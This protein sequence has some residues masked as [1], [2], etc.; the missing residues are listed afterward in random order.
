MVTAALAGLCC[1][2]G[3]A[4][5]QLSG[6]TFQYQ[7]TYVQTSTAAPT[8]SNLHEYTAVLSFPN[9]QP[10]SG[11]D[12]AR[13]EKPSGSIVQ[14]NTSSSFYSS[15]IVF[16]PT[17]EAMQAAWPSGLYTFTIARRDE[18]DNEFQDVYTKQQPYPTG[19]WPGQ[20]PTFTAAS[21]NGLQ[22]MSPSQPR[23]VEVNAFSVSAPANGQLSGLSVNQRFGTLQGP[24]AWSSLTTIGAP[25][26][27]RTIPAGVLQ[28]NT[29]YYATWYFAQR[30]VSQPSAQIAYSH[31][32]FDNLTR[33]AFRTGGLSCGPADIAGA[34][35]AV[36]ADGQLTADDIIVF[37][38]WFFAADVRADIA[39]SGQTPTPDGQFTADDIILFINRFFAGC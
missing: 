11:V 31:V 25:T 13:V 33:V 6:L 36:G 10:P 15:P 24:T 14:L 20:I 29:D 22:G 8:T 26:S 5:A 27:T 2:S 4:S 12:E 19:V 37:I 9:S 39:T 1:P 35:Q 30:V 38:G 16:Y 28:P 32:S 21:F 34:G 3:N 7:S 18:D 17:R 23:T